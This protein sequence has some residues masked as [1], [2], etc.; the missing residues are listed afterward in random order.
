MVADKYQDKEKFILNN[1]LID[2][3]F[4]QSIDKIKETD[5]TIMEQLDYLN[6]VHCNPLHYLEENN[7]T[8]PLQECDGGV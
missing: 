7:S 5:P 8:T 4:N 3:K 1:S 2:V 6:W